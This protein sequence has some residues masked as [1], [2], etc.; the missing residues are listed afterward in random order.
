M[1]QPNADTLDG[2]PSAG[3]IRPGQQQDRCNDMG[4]LPMD[5]PT[6]PSEADQ[7]TRYHPRRPFNATVHTLSPTADTGL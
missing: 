2:T 7:R 1:E 3:L 5:R 4:E 6:H